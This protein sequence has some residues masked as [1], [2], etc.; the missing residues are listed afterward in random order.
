MHE[1]SGPDS[2]VL[3]VS[4]PTVLSLIIYHN[5]FHLIMAYNITNPKISIVKSKFI[6]RN[7]LI[8]W[9]I[10]IAKSTFFPMTPK[11]IQS[12]VLGV[13]TWKFTFYMG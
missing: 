13:H 7:Y 5:I 12:T 3:V 4:L 11:K 6:K 9:S 10:E 2:R 1:N 8:F